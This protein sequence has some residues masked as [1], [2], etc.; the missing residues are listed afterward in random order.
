[1]LIFFQTDLLKRVNY[2]VFANAL[3]E[4]QMFGKCLLKIWKL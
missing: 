1:M 2:V 4:M 3:K